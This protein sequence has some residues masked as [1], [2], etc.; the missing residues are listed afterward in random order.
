MLK[1]IL[2]IAS[3]LLITSAQ[4]QISVDSLLQEIDVKYTKTA[5]RDYLMEK[6]SIYESADKLDRYDLFLDSSNQLQ[7]NIGLSV[8]HYAYDVQNRLVLIEGFNSKGERSY[9][10]FP[11]VQRFT[12][13][14]DTVVSVFNQLKNDYCNCQHEERLSS[15]MKTQEIY[16]NTT[17]SKTRFHMYSND[18]TMRLTY[19]IC[20]NGKVCNRGKNV[21]YVFRV[22]DKHYPSRIIHERYYD[23]QLQLIDGEH[24]VYETEWLSFN[25]PVSYAYSERELIDG[26]LSLVRF[27]N[28]KKELIH[29]KKYNH[30]GGPINVPSE[31]RVE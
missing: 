2:C 8:V 20:S 6:F 25:S 30:H 31:G 14:H 28:A 19:S 9:W 3:L 21:A 10:D 4:S 23:D 15:V 18:S 13:T 1:S 7:E 12:H 17:Y 26:N 24:S 29:S 5:E 11:V 27:Y 16:R 22:F